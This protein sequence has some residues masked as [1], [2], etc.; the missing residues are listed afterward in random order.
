MSTLGDH[1]RDEKSVCG[2][3]AGTGVLARLAQHVIGV[4]TRSKPELA[5]E[6]VG[7]KPGGRTEKKPAHARAGFG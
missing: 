5:G 2:D 1:S 3:E 6:K 7:S 4:P